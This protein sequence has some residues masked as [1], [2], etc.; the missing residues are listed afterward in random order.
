MPRGPSLKSIDHAVAANSLALLAALLYVSP[1]SS[2][3]AQGS[4]PFTVTINLLSSDPSGGTA[5][6]ATCRTSSGVGVFGAT[7]TVVCSTGAFVN[8]SGNSSTLPWTKTPSSA[9]RYLIAPYG[10]GLPLGTIDSYT[11]VGTITTWRTI[12][13]DHQDYLEMMVHW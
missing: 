4:R 7:L 3:A 11:G 12:H 8:Y 5:N 13:L 6:S 2:E 1:I 10:A 9:F